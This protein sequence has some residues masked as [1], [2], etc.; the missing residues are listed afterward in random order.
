MQELTLAVVG[1]TYANADKSKSSR[2]YELLLCKPGDRIDLQLEPK[3]EHDS[4]AIAVFSERGVQVGYL[5]AERAPWIGA[6]IRSG[7][8]VVAVFQGLVDNA[9]YI[10]VRFG[11]G[12]PTLP[13][14]AEAGVGQPHQHRELPRTR[15]AIDPDGFY[16]D[17]EGP[18]WG[19]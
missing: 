7:E 10:R 8:E 6:R 12:A 18:E 9:A 13:P 17:P 4:N 3:N 2:L 1:I 5:T 14:S 11:G 16:P 15:A 19:A